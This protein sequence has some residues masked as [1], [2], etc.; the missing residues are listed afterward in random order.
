M[1]SEVLGVCLV[2]TDG[3]TVWVN[4]LE[5]GAVGRFG[6]LAID[7]HNPAN[8]SCEDC[9]PIG[10]NFPGAWKRFR[11]GM[12]RVHNFDVP[13]SFRP[14]WVDRR[15]EA[16]SLQSGHDRRQCTNRGEYKWD[17]HD[18]CWLHLHTAEHPERGG[19]VIWKDEVDDETNT[20]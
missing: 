12:K 18:C 4:T 11:I 7:V 17:G 13:E 10:D 19:G 15:C 16:L 2:E 3:R 20:D 5:G 9:G 6:R 1:R 14:D 8:N